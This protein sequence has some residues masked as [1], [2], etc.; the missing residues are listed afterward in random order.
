MPTAAVVESSQDV[1]VKTTTG[2]QHETAVSGRAGTDN[3]RCARAAPL[4]YTPAGSR[5]AA[6][7]RASYAVAAATALLPF[8]FARLPFAA[9]IGFAVFTEIPDVWVWVGGFVIFAASIYMAHREAVAARV[10][11][12]G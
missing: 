8:D 3:P 9:A 11:A 12:P 4:R 6:I 1:A 7:R 5:R 10:K 2:P